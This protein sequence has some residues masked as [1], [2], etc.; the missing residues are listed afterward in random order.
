MIALILADAVYIG[1][2]SIL[3]VLLVI[4]II[5]IILRLLKII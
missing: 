1:G 5:L 4:V 3:G 2:G